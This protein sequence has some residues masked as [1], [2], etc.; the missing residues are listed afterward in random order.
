MT[1]SSMTSFDLGEIIADRYRLEGRIGSGATSDV[2]V[3]MDIRDERQV[4]VKLLR[5]RGPQ[6]TER[7]IREADAL[8][9]L[10]HPSVVR[11]LGHHQD[12][13]LLVMELLVG[14]TLGK[15]LSA[16]WRPS[17]AEV[18][19]I[20]SALA[21]AL[22]HVHA[23]GLIHRDIKPT[24]VLLTR[25][26]VVL[27]DFGLVR[28]LASVLTRP[29]Q[30]LGTIGYLAPEAILGAHPS[31]ATDLY[32]L[33][34]LLQELLTGKAPTPHSFREP[35][36]QIAE[37]ALHE[38]PVALDIDDHVLARVV[39][40]CLEPDPARRPTAARVAQLLRERERPSD[41][42]LLPPAPC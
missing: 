2:F 11:V 7:F 31:P 19:R 24:N 22:A 9:F 39:Q 21:E 5:L 42:E 26:R 25:D 4:A 36:R 29:G 8:H 6:A 1:S 33:G 35:L 34:C 41:P 30:V 27:F 38:A 17:V 18:R 37:R 32:A 12:P 28:G 10:E 14:E 20:A 3:A 13:P 23:H 40:S 15:R 16:G